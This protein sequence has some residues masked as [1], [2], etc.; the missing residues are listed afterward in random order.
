ML[1]LIH[2]SPAGSFSK[3]WKFGSSYCDFV[4]K[5]HCREVLTELYANGTLTG[6]IGGWMG[7]GSCSTAEDGPAAAVGSGA[8]SAALWSCLAVAAGSEELDASPAVAVAGAASLG[9]AAVSCALPV[10]ALA[11]ITSVFSGCDVAVFACPGRLTTTPHFCR[12]GS[13]RGG[14]G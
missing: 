10:P 7:A 2:R 12:I 11:S 8:A 3:G 4:A 13:G 6:W 1:S 14:L 5:M 9:K